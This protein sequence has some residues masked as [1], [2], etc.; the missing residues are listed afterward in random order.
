MLMRK[1]CF[2]KRPGQRQAW[3][4]HYPACTCVLPMILIKAGSPTPLH[5]RGRLEEL[6]LFDGHVVG[7]LCIRFRLEGVM[8]PL[9]RIVAEAVAGHGLQ[10]A[11]AI[12]MLRF[13]DQR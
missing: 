5:A 13:G 12:G 3:A 11:L 2:W 9:H 8:P 6:R 4:A 7:G 10:Q 1:P